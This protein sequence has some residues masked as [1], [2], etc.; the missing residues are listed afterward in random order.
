MIL[1]GINNLK[2]ILF[3]FQNSCLKHFGT[4]FSAPIEFKRD[5]YDAGYDIWKIFCCFM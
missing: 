3:L 5:D 2:N 4:Y 1:Y